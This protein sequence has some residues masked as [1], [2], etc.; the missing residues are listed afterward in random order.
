MYKIIK[1][2]KDISC[3]ECHVNMPTGKVVYTND[4]ETEFFCT[5]VCMLKYTY[6]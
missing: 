4:A 3:N 1:I 5:R 6:P 2:T